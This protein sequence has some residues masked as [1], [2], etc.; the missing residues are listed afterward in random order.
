MFSWWRGSGGEVTTL[1]VNG[2]LLIGERYPAPR[3]G[4]E[5]SVEQRDVW[6]WGLKSE[7][8]TAGGLAAASGV[9]WGWPAPGLLYVRFGPGAL[10]AGVSLIYPVL[11]TTIAAAV[12]WH[13]DR[14][15]FGPGR[16]AKCGYARAGLAADAACPECGTVPASK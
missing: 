14:R 5:W 10:T 15:R 6:H 8:T 11:F 2:G 12:L 9:P 13:A 3:T 4:Q 1:I 16:C 7:G